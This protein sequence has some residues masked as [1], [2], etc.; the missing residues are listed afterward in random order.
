M[1]SRAVIS[2]IYRGEI[3]ADIVGRPKVWYSISGLL[4]ALSIAGLLV[5]GLNF[6]VEFKGGSVFT[7]KAPSASI[8]QVRGA[9]AEGGV[10]QI[11]VQKAG[12]DW[13]V[14]TESLSSTEVTK[15]KSTVAEELNV[16]A[17]KVSTQV[18]GASWGGQIQKKAW[19]ALLVFMILIIGYLSVAFEWRMAVAAVVALV[20][21][22]VI[23]AGVYAWSG[24][25]VTPATLLGF[26]TILG[27]S[28][29]DAVVVFD[30]I[31]EVTKPLTAT[32][33]TTYSEAA[34]QALSSTLVR[35]LN[36]SLVAILPVGAIL[37]IGTTLFGAGTLKD[38]SL[39]L[40]VGMI[41]GTYSSICV[42]TPLLVQFKEREPKFKQIR[43]NIARREQSAKR[44][45]KTLKVKTGARGAGDASDDAPED[46]PDGAPSGDADAAP[47]VR[48]TVTVRKVVQTGTRQQPK[49]GTR[50]QRRGGK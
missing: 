30:M 46:T 50:Q 31:K 10:H 23:T 16:S 29:Y 42:A 43:E 3:S 35:S 14:T 34:N 6:G 38:L 27:Y 45:A 9:V 49:R 41:V 21:D 11:I 39:A 7:F 2:R 37:F 47:D 15:V 28:L 24:F 4:L 5:Q 13:R 19:Q 20:H 1:G 17:D 40:F 44:Q 8:E 32:S 12:G 33:K 18:V 25:E 48:S 26:L 22:L 36:T